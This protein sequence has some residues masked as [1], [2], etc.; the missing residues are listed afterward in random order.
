[1]QLLYRFAQTQYI[2]SFALLRNGIRLPSTLLSFCT[3][4]PSTQGRRGRRAV[5]SSEE[6]Q[7]DSP[8][9]RPAA[10]KPVGRRQA[11]SKKKKDKYDN[12]TIVDLDKLQVHRS[13]F[14]SPCSHPP[15]VILLKIS[16]CAAYSESR[17]LACRIWMKCRM[18]QE[19]SQAWYAISTVFILAISQEFLCFLL[20]R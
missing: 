20:G 19:I 6:E 1:M 15:S 8:P 7:S 9:P 16:C 4:S 13:L 3:T 14:V 11:R 5:E 12:D 18:R 2:L 10:R 17:V